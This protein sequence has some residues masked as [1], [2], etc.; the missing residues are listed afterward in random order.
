MEVSDKNLHRVAVTATIY[1][2]ERKFLI[3][4]RALE[5]KH[6]PGSWHVPGGGMTSDDYTN[7][8]SSTP[9]HNQ[10]RNVLEIALRREIKEETTLEIGKLEMLC[11]LA[12]IRKD[13]L[14][15]LVISYFAPYVS[16]EVKISPE[17]MDF[18]WVTLE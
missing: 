1:N 17:D 16:G 6:F 5:L 3:T 10:W 11:D 14:P 15:T 2:S 13:G 12:F 18:A 7:L 9:N 4:R 8:P